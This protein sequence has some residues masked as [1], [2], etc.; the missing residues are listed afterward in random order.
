MNH[1][2][3]RGNIREYLFSYSKIFVFLCYR[4]LTSTEFIIPLSSSLQKNTL[5]HPQNSIEQKQRFTNSTYIPSMKQFL[6]VRPK[7]I[8]QKEYV[9]E[10]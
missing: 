2:L 9:D 4:S 8:K 6:S 1:I 7:L 10:N 5:L 3:K